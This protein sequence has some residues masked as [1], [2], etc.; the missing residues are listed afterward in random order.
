MNAHS[1][2]QKV[3]SESQVSSDAAGDRE[4]GAEQQ[5]PRAGAADPGDDRP[6]EAA[7]WER[8]AS[9]AITAVNLPRRHELRPVQDQP[10]G[11]P[12]RLDPV[13]GRD[14][15]PDR[16]GLLEVAG[17]RRDLGD[18]EAEVRGLHQQLGVEDEVDR[19]AQERDRQ[20][21][22][23]AVGAVAGVQVGELGAQDPVLD[24][25]QRAVGDP[26]VERHARRPA[27][28]RARPSGC[29][30]RGPPRPSR[31]RRDQ[32]R[33]QARAR[34]GRRGA[35]SPRSPPRAEA[36]RGSRSSGC[37]R[38]RRCAGARRRGRRAPG[39]CL[40]RLVGGPVVDEDDLVDPVARDRGDRG[41]ERLGRVERRHHD[42]G[43]RAAGSD[44]ARLHVDG[45]A[46]AQPRPRRARSRGRERQRERPGGEDRRGAAP[47]ES[48][49][50]RAS[51]RRIAS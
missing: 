11:R 21:E 18:P 43:L 5:R 4:R 51:G 28:R 47:G 27:R 24:R 20:Q 36:P 9:L 13:D 19:V 48:G 26:L 45:A 40:T 30:A 3:R 38:S 44:T 31:D 14:P 22:L 15:R 23:A 2:R 12:Q 41:L 16:R 7:R 32:L 25:R 17:A 29:R 42:H 37:R 49:R 46:A 10:A 50:R 6:L 33:D 35:A 1:S 39:R 34:T 8:R